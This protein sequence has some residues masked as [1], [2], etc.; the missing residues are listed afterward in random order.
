MP[1]GKIIPT[2]VFTKALFFYKETYIMV[3]IVEDSIKMWWHKLF[4]L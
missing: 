3:D 4:I 1:D 2:F